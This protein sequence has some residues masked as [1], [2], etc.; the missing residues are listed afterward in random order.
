MN[1]ETRCDAN[2]L[3]RGMYSGQYDNKP[4][5]LRKKVGIMNRMKLCALLT[6]LLGFVLG[7][8]VTAQE[9]APAP[10]AHDKGKV[11]SHVSTDRSGKTTT[12]TP[13]KLQH[14]T[15]MTHRMQRKPMMNCQ[16]MVGGK[17]MNCKNMKDC[18]KMMG[19]KSTMNCKHMVGGKSMNC[20]N[21]KDCKNMMGGKSKMNCSNMD[22][23]S[24]KD[25]KHLKD[26]KPMTADKS[27]K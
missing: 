7:M 20:K 22:S 21:M 3:L 1:L 18:K 14:K 17:S 10:L 24:M 2:S 23:K 8:P 26:T 27:K 16:H 13:K 9:T 12:V 25:G 6:V 5:I 4:S 15:V 11:T 19:G